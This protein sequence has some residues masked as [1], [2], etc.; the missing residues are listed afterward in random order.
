MGNIAGVCGMR[1]NYKFVSYET[2][3]NYINRKGQ[4]SALTLPPGH[5]FELID[6]TKQSNGEIKESWETRPINPQPLCI[7][8]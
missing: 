8:S 4:D 1:T 3:T 2:Y 5:L 6:A 7:I